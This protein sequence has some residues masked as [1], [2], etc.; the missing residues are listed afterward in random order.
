M[1]G[2]FVQIHY[3]NR[4]G[5]VTTVM[6][7]YSRT[8]GKACGASCS[9]LVVCAR[10]RTTI[11]ARGV[12]IVDIKD[13][14]YRTF[15]SRA[16]FFKTRGR[17]FD[18]L[19]QIIM[20]GNLPRPVRVV[21][22]N[23]NLGKNCALSS[24]FAQ[25]ARRC[26]KQKNE[27]RFYSVVH[28]FAEEGRHDLMSKLI[29]LERLGIKIWDEL[30]PAVPGLCFVALNNRNYG[31]LKKAGFQVRLLPNLV[32]IPPAGQSYS[33]YNR[34]KT[35][36]ALSQMAEKDGTAFNPS[37]PVVF[38]PSRIISRKNPVEAILLSQFFFSSNLLLGESGMSSEDRAL[39]AR[40]KRLCGRYKIPVIFNSGR[41]AGFLS[42]ATARAFPATWRGVSGRLT[43]IFSLGKEESPPLGAGFFNDVETPFSFLY[44]AADVCIS[45][46]VLE[47]FG[48]ALYEPWLYHKAVVGRVPAKS[49][50][51]KKITVPWLYSRLLIPC[52]WVDIKKL[53][54]RYYRDMGKC[55]VHE[56]ALPGFKLF[57][58]QFNRAFVNKG[59]IDFGCLDLATQCEVLEGLCKRPELVDEWMRAFPH[60][61]KALMDSWKAA[62]A[63]PPMFAGRNRKRVLSLFGNDAFASSFSACFE[64]MP[65]AHT[66][67]RPRPAALQKRLCGLDTFRQLT[68]RQ[69]PNQGHYCK[70]FA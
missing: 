52:A 33:S 38:Y 39:A 60:Q 49:Y 61:T 70:I 25:C 63:R 36:A 26:A 3:H 5:G 11:D 32:S 22:H 35:L 34:K 20:S 15:A 9:N 23:L 46:S 24:A 27:Y 65:R 4:P 48:Y 7:H 16:A 2:S 17:L 10:E 68:A 66:P 40:L 42:N 28:D 67:A 21:G 13:F 44:R 57:I 45:T 12:K 58:K 62:T 29:S 56:N 1:K 43:N 18:R 51:Q 55:L 59:G 30:Y 19:C 14:G 69:F 53:A 31:F 8:F 6:G 54:E 41:A 64:K 50:V 47:G 37:A